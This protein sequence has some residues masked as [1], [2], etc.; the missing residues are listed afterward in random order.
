[1]PAISSGTAALTY[2]AQA[3]T[4]LLNI[5]TSSSTDMI[6]SQ[7]ITSARRT[8]IPGQATTTASGE[9][10]YDQGDACAAAMEADSVSATSRSV[11]ITYA[12]G[13]TISGSAFVSSWQV[14][15]QMNDTLRAS[16]E[17]QFTG[18]V[19]IA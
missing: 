16:F 17:L 9:L 18:T 1:M 5:S 7:A 2:N 10:Y 11:T 14:T 4:G 6:E 8:F 15:A 19:T 13:M 12:T 3:T